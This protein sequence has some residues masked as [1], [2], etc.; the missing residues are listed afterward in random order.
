MIKCNHDCFN[1]TFDDCIVDEI[2]QKEK[3]DSHKRDI[4]FTDYGTVVLKA[5]PSR[6]KLR[7]GKH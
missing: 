3:R 7:G 6:S 4:N 2:S 1:C 5:R